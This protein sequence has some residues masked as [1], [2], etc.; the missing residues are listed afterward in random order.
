MYD[1]V[2]PGSEEYDTIRS[3]YAHFAANLRR[4]A[5]GQTVEV[6]TCWGGDEGVAP[7]QRRAIDAA[8]IASAGFDFLERELITIRV[9]DA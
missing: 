6:Y 8:D 7:E 3:A 5:P 4:H 9:D 1:G 2:E